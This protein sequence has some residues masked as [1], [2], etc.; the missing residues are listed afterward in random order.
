MRSRSRL[1][2][3]LGA[4]LLALVFAG[5]TSDAPLDTLDPAGRK[6]EDI[7][8]LMMFVLYLSGI[9]LVAVFAVLGFI[10]WKFR[11]RKPGPDDTHYAGDY[12]DE[13]FPAQTHGNF[14]LEIGWTIA[15]T[16]LMAVI[17]IISIA[18]LVKL[19]DVEAAPPGS[20]HPDMEIVVV[21][22]QWWWEY[23]YYLDGTEGADAPDF[24][25][26]DE[27]IIPVDRDIQLY[28][29]SR[30]VIH[31][32]WIPRLNGKRDA[33]PG[34][35]HT[36]VIQSNEVGRFA[37]SCTEFCGLSHAYMRMYTV[38]LPDDEF[39]DWAA[40]QATPREPLSSI[41][42]NYEGE[43]LFLANCQRC[44]VVDGVTQRVRDGEGDRV[45]DDMAMYDVL[46]D[47][48]DLSDGPLTQGRYTEPG[49]LTSGAA[50]NLSH[51][52]ART[53]YAGSFF[54]L[55]PDAQQRTVDGGYLD[56]AGSD[57]NR[58]QLEAWLRDAPTEKPAYAEGLR[59]MPNLN[60]N[61]DEID[62]LVDYLMSLD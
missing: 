31:S 16:I 10:A 43:Q 50:P 8:S 60:L 3:A 32:F 34:R 37:G 30:D 58:G 42:P 49:N 15:P 17:A 1:V 62:L 24:V 33:A 13:E 20:A 59:G 11:V 9:I 38:A 44:H 48:R 22:Q 14:N 46:D 18:A 36:W 39:A 52:A 35:V 2:P 55:Y 56:F 28:I 5:C 47:Y 25:T 54:D 6:A 26:A 40:N 45:P 21:G 12:P 51:F 23:H 57:F 29:T 4:L 53:S 19:D 7:D 41:D 61:E 27:M